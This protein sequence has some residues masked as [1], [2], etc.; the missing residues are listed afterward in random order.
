ME[1]ESELWWEI[2]SKLVLVI[3]EEVEE[4]E[5]GLLFLSAEEMNRLVYH[6]SPY[7]VISSCINGL[8]GT[9]CEL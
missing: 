4:E 3:N 1:H 6:K 5:R 7:F 8:K 2:L 9:R